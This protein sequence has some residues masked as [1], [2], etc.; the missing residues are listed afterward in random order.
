MK[1]Y[2]STEKTNV[3]EKIK[4]ILETKAIDYE[5]LESKTFPDST[6][7]E[8][9]TNDRMIAVNLMAVGASSITF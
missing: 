5:H 2:V 3:V 9:H 1:V 4:E 7:F 6:V 8:L